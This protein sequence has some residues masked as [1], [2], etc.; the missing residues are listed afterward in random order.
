MNTKRTPA[1]TP[2]HG[3]RVYSYERISTKTQ[4]AGTGIERQASY[5]AKWAAE[6]RLVLDTSLNLRDEGL[7]ANHQKHVKRGALGMFLRVVEESRRGKPF[8]ENSSSPDRATRA[9][10]NERSILSFHS[11]VRVD[12]HVSP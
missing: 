8:A 7:S 12:R 4:S 10:G 5:A 1:S 3:R 11:V 9:E 2:H 6:R